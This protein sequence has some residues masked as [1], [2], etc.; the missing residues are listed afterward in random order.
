MDYVYIGSRAYPGQWPMSIW[1]WAGTD[2]KVKVCYCMPW[3]MESGAGVPVHPTETPGGTQI[4]SKFHL[5][6]I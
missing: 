6:N 2:H 5:R 3:N 1:Y 4:E